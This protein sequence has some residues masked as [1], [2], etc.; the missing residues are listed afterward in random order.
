MPCF[1]ITPSPNDVITLVLFRAIALVHLCSLRYHCGISGIVRGP[2]SL[3][4]RIRRAKV[5]RSFAGSVLALLGFLLESAMRCLEQKPM[6]NLPQSHSRTR[7]G[8]EPPAFGGV[9][10][11]HES[12]G[13]V[14]ARQWLSLLLRP[15]S[16][17]S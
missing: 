1:K 17:V 4:P 8:N 14:R 11:V 2:T 5:R 6:A 10:F 7:Y 15:Q 13:R 9:I 16:Y 12:L 3:L